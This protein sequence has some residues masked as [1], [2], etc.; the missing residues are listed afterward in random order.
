MKTAVDAFHRAAE[1]IGWRDGLEP[2]VGPHG[3][4]IAATVAATQAGLTKLR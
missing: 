2:L 4:A 1:W 3:A